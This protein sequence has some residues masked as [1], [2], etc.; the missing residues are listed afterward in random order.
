[1]IPPP[2]RPITAARWTRSGTKLRT[3]WHVAVAYDPAAPKSLCH[4]PI[5]AGAE[6]REVD[7]ATLRLSGC[8]KCYKILLANGAKRAAAAP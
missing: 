7:L 1:M 2:A 4:T 5:P 3:S 6:R 8:E